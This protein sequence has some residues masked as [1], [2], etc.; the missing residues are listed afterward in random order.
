VPLHPNYSP[1]L[2]APNPLL[3]NTSLTP[4]D[5]DK[6][7]LKSSLEA[8]LLTTEEFSSGSSAWARFTNPFLALDSAAASA[9]GGHVRGES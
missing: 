6:A 8:A 9:E 1:L 7:S 3:H 4:Q 2:S 5:C